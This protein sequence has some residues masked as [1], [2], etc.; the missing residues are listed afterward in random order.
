MHTFYSRVK[1]F[2]D[3]VHLGVVD[4]VGL[5]VLELRRGSVLHRHRY[6]S[7]SMVMRTTLNMFIH[8]LKSFLTFFKNESIILR[9]VQDDIYH[10][11]KSV[12]HDVPEVLGKP[13]CLF[14]SRNRT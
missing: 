5:V 2:E 7:N 10:V 6:T 9:F 13:P 4:Y 12:R 11:R 3:F 8:I 14:Y 1:K